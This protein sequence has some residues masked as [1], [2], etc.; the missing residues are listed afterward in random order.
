M[1][2]VVVVVAV[3]KSRVGIKPV[4]NRAARACSPGRRG[5]SRRTRSEQ[6]RARG[7]RKRRERERETQ[8]KER[9]RTRAEKAG[10]NEKQRNE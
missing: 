7:R 3:K 2:I 1:V 10:S 4:S 9:K 6:R 5:S 8:K